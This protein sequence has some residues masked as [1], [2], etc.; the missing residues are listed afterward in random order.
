M[1]S[2]HNLIRTKRY[3]SVVLRWLGVAV[4]IFAA[5]M[6]TGIYVTDHLLVKIYSATASMQVQP[7]LAG[8][9][10]YGGWAFSTPQSRAVQAELESIE[11]PEI[12]RGVVNGLALDKA[13]ADRIFS[14]KEPLTLEEAVHYLEGHLRLKFKHDSGIVEITALSD[15]PKEA[16]LIA[17]DVVELYKLAHD[18]RT[19]AG[20]DPGARATANAGQ[21]N[22]VHVAAQ[23]VVPTEPT[24]P[25][26]RFC[27]AIAAGLGGMLAVMIASSLEVCLLIARAEQATAELPP[28]R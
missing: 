17:N 3:V 25:N 21:S 22:D 14:R 18:N 16:A 19:G 5:T 8:P 6:V 20:A 1:T 2:D 27:Y 7:Q 26:K 11:S 23:A 12:M 9:E 4:F 10:A 28:A 13:W 15:D 24:L